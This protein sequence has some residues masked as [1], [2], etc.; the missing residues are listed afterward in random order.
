LYDGSVL[1][2]EI[3]EVTINQ[4]SPTNTSNFHPNQN[5]PNIFCHT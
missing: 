1:I 5:T 2:Y 3:P 4:Q